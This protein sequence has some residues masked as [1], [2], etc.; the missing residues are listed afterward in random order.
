M[1][2]QILIQQVW[3]GT[4]RSAFPAS[5]QDAEAA[6]SETTLR[7]PGS[8]IQ[9]C[10]MTASWLATSRGGGWG[11]A[12]GGPALGVIKPM[13]YLVVLPGLLPARSPQ[14]SEFAM[15]H[16]EGNTIGQN[17]RFTRCLVAAGWS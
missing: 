14:I 13:S 1:K 10:N 7:T 12:L 8:W 6:P 4:S 11:S 2:M 5:P 3:G 17:P 15:S 16:L 9:A